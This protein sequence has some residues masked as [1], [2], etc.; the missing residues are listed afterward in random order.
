MPAQHHEQ[1]P[2][3]ALLRQFSMSAGQFGYLRASG[4][5][6]DHRATKGKQQK[7]AKRETKKPWFP[8]NILDKRDI[9]LVCLNRE[10]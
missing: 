5:G 1:S 4:A 6:V 3:V 8:F 9:C 10:F 2:Q 7:K